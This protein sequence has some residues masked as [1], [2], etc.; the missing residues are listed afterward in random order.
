MRD[1]KLKEFPGYEVQLETS[2]NEVNLTKAPYNYNGTVLSGYLKVGKGNSA[3][4]FIFYG[5]EGLERS[6]INTVPTVLWL[7]GGPGSSSQLGNLMELG[8]F[9]VIKSLNKPYEIVRNNYT[10]VKD[11]NV[12]FVDQPVGTGLSYADQTF[13]NVYVTNQTDLA[14]DFYKALFELYNNPNGCFQRVNIRGDH[15][16]FI[17]GESYGGKY[18]PA[19]GLKIA[20]EAK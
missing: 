8:P 1:G 11:Y 13:P 9:W 19:I 10:W 18:A 7:N 4:G 17:F 6:K 12:I 3:L 20:T 15:P 16:L 5:K 2:C 14:N